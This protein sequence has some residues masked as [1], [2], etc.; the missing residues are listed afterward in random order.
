[1]K[2]MRSLCLLLTA[3]LLV[4]LVY[5]SVLGL[6]AYS[7]VLILYPMA[8]MLRCVSDDALLISRKG[9]ERREPVHLAVWMPGVWCAVH[10]LR[11]DLIR[12]GTG[13]PLG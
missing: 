7:Y 6:C 10:R 13:P 12:Y 1:M 4:L 9:S 3:V 5:S 2:G 11:L 8:P